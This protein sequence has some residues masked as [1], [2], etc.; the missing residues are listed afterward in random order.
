MPTHCRLDTYT[1]GIAFKAM[2]SL[3]IVMNSPVGTYK[4]NEIHD[5]RWPRSLLL[6]QK[7]RMKK[8]GLSSLILSLAF[9][10]ACGD[11]T[12]GV[13]VPTLE[14]D[15]VEIDVSLTPFGATQS[16]AVTLRSVGSASLE[17]ERLTLVGASDGA[18]VPLDLALTVSESLPKRLAP[19]S[20]FEVQIA[21]LPRDTVLDEGRLLVASDD[22][23]RPLAFV[24]IRQRAVGAPRIAAVPDAE[25]AVLEAS[26]AGGVRSFVAAV[27]FGE[28]QVGLQKVE[29]LHV[30]NTGGGGL[31]LEVTEVTLSPSVPGL[32]L[33]LEPDANVDPLLLAA[34]STTSL[35]SGVARSFRVELSYAPPTTNSTVSTVLFVHS[36]DPA[37]PV[38]EIPISGQGPGIDPPLMRIS[39]PGPLDFGAARVGQTVDRA[40]TVHNDGASPLELEPL[41]LTDNPAGVFS[42]LE[43]AMAQSIAPG[44]NRVFNLRFSPVATGVVQGSLRIASTSAG[45]SAL[46]YGLRGEGSV[47][48]ACTPS[49]VDPTE[50]GNG[51]CEGAQDRGA[52][53]LSGNQ[54]EQRSFT[55]Q[56]FERD[57][58]EDWSRYTIEVDGGCTLIG[59]EVT[60][61]ITPPPGEQA[62]VCVSLGACDSPVRENCSSGTA[63]ILLLS[64]TATCN[65][66]SNYV[67]FYVRTYRTGGALSCEPYT[68][69]VTAR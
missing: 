5:F 7:P 52:I 15:P 63:S 60:A 22:P 31:P 65:A 38:F 53:F 42:L 35:R 26:T 11:E 12:I 13:Q 34:L 1:A 19:N 30:V 48:Q 25:A 59:Y 36:S 10:A 18:P 55:G 54:T 44:Q 46:T 57:S 68:V 8:A 28:V 33:R 20:S 40:I 39:P 29:T 2:L 61:R 17:V 9:L 4:R 14:I 45:V 67:P 51:A 43:A 16:Y 37:T 66:F 21:H 47:E 62:Q 3:G 24:P 49:N 64:G 6:V 58:D 27:R 50:P 56:V 41:V 23:S 32:E 69:N